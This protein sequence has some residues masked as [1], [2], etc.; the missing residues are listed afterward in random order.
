MSWAH[1]QAGVGTRTATPGI[2]TLTVTF[3]S[4]VTAGNLIVV[5]ISHQAGSIATVADNKSNGNYLAA[6][7]NSTFTSIYYLQVPNGGSSFTITV[8]FNVAD[9]P[10]ITAD[11]FSVPAGTLAA[12]DSS[13][14]STGTG[15]AVSG[16][17]LTIGGSDLVYGIVNSSGTT[18]VSYTAIGSYTLSF[19]AV[20]VIGTADG[21]AAQYIL[22]DSTT[23]QSTTMTLGSSVTWYIT[24]VAFKG[25]SG[26]ALS[27]TTGGN[28]SAANSW[29]GAKIP[30]IPHAISGAADNGSGLIRI[31]TGT[32]TNWN[33]GDI[34]NI[35]GVLGTTEATGNWVVTVID[36][37]HADLQSSTFTHTYTSG[38]SAFRGETVTLQGPIALDSGAVDASGL[39]IVGSDPGNSGTAAITIGNTAQTAEVSL[40][41]AGG[42]QTLRLRG[43][44]TLTG[45]NV[46]GGHYSTLSLTAGDSLVFDPR[47]A[48]HYLMNL[49]YICRI[50]ANGTTNTGVW[51]D[52]SGGNHCVIKTDTARGGTNAYTVILNGIPNTGT[53][54]GGLMTATFTDLSHLGT[55]TQYGICL[56]MDTTTYGHITDNI[57]IT[58]NT[59]N[60]T[61]YVLLAES[62]SYTGNYQYN[63]NLVT[64][65]VATNV[66]SQLG[67]NWHVIQTATGASTRTINNNSIDCVFTMDRLT[68]C[69]IQGN[70][71][72][73]SIGVGNVPSWTSAS[74]LSGNFIAMPAGIGSGWPICSYQNNYVYYSGVSAATLFYTASSGISALNNIYDSAT[75]GGSAVH[76]FP[77]GGAITATGNIILQVPSTTNAAAT[78][79]FQAAYTATVEHNLMVGSNPTEGGLVSL[80]YGAAAAAGQAV[81]VRANLIYCASSAN[82]VAAVTEVGSSTFTKDAV[83]VAGYNGFFGPTSG[84]C[85]YNAGVSSATVVGYA[86]L[87]VT[88]ATAFA[89]QGG[90]AG[91][92]Q[93]QSGFDLTANPNFVDTSLRNVAKWNNV[94]QGG[95]ATYAAAIATLQANPGLLAGMLTWVRAG[96]APTN[97]LLNAASYSGDGSTADANG[98]AWP[99]GAP[100]VGPMAY[101][102][103]SSS[104]GGAALMMGM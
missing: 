76:Y 42:G 88:N 41:T 73:G 4:A 24:S 32:A 84:T 5:G 78:L 92:T 3:G 95:A 14:S 20:G 56:Y 83:T 36:T 80:G 17:N 22:N 70:I 91:N 57:T 94:T 98:N 39:I 102:A 81:S 72:A 74:M 82:Y 25:V 75:V 60:D 19:S 59:W 47:S 45:S 96:Y 104:V 30:A 33:T 85:K 29:I 61:S 51:P 52:T 53:V 86:N 62:G 7:T 13:V 63:N 67:P 90:G 79:F 44:L 48:S 66:F 89:A 93:I 15:T 28:W 55:T 31:T 40:T 64:S 11:E 10:T 65:S 6:A 58:N 8:T 23:P 50:L 2:T 100:G 26:T 46:S 97:V 21:G 103:A 9:Y 37:T 77:S 1:A 43:D 69:T 27:T 101:Q 34:V 12:V 38:G 87:E 35:L 16:G 71:F 54:V 18:C 68:N 99:G 49:Q